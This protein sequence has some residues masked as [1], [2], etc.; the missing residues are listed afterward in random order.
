MLS[1]LLR[2][3]ARAGKLRPRP[4]N[5]DYAMRALPA[6]V[7]LSSLAAPI[8]GC[9]PTIPVKDDFG[10][11]TLVPAGKAVPPEFAEFNAY[12]PAVAP[13][14]ADQVCATQ[15][16]PLEQKSL[17]AIPGRMVQLQGRCRTHVPI[18]GDPIW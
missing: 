18:F 16:Q 12:D 1:R 5:R 11:S 17:D 10:V 7:L 4:L 6:L 2:R 13:I 3:W 9:S 14:L 8:V 15:Y